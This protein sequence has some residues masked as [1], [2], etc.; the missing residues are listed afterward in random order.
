MFKGLGTALAVILVGVLLINC[1][2]YAEPESYRA[3]IFRPEVIENKGL[4]PFFYSSLSFGESSPNGTKDFDKNCQEWVQELGSGVKRKDVNFILYKIPLEFFFELYKED[5][6]EEVLEGNTF[7]AA[8]AKKPEMMAYLIYSKQCELVHYMSNAYHLTYWG[9]AM[10]VPDLKEMIAKAQEGIDNSKSKFLQKRYAFQL[11]KNTWLD[12]QNVVECAHLVDIHFTSPDKSGSIL[13]S[14]AYIFRAY[15]TSIKG[16][17]AEANY[18]LSKTFH[19]SDYRKIRALQ[20]F[21]NRDQHVEMATTFCKNDPERSVIYAMSAFS[22]PGKA[23]NEIKL[24]FSKDNGSEYLP[25]LI[26]REINKL[27]DWLYTPWLSGFDPAVFNYSTLDS[28]PQDNTHFVKKNY[29]K[30]ASYLGTFKTF[31]ESVAAKSSNKNFY[32][33][34]LAQL[35]ILSNNNAEA[36]KRLSNIASNAPE[37]I[38]LQKATAELLIKSKTE[39]IESPEI[40][41]EMGNSLA[42]LS[43]NLSSTESNKKVLNAV[44][45]F[46]SKQYQ[47]KGNIPM[48]ALFYHKSEMHKSEY[49]GWPASV[50]EG[51]FS[52]IDANSISFYWYLAYLNEHASPEQITS[53]I[54]L[55]ENPKQNELITYLC[56]QPL[57][58]KNAYLD[59]KATKL[60]NSD[61]LEEA[62]EAIKNVPDS[63][64]MK[65]YEFNHYLDE[66]PFIGVRDNGKVVRKTE[67]YLPSKKK[68]LKDLIAYKKAFEEAPEK[69]LEKGL[70][71]ANAYYNTTWFGNSWMYATYG[72]S[73]MDAPSGKNKTFEDNYFYC[74]KAAAYYKKV[75][76]S[77]KPD[78]DP[79]LASFIH[80]MAYLCDRN[81]TLF[82]PSSTASVDELLAK[83]IKKGHVS[84][85]AIHLKYKNTSTYGYLSTC[86]AFKDYVSSF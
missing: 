20:A 53:F 11:L 70:Y 27:E 50:D 64:W 9:E 85:E 46:L 62:Y 78:T 40:Q 30:D 79:E 42:F 32:N 17:T 67:P 25:T 21:S 36:Q 75:V 13:D 57:A 39:N 72:Q 82:L 34:A 76:S 24:V 8:L 26:A 2:Y 55:I 49:A 52:Y 59:L 45:M 54:S 66:S 69:N 28:E 83:F 47:T 15:E 12:S 71:V 22:Q 23:L 58:S 81:Q 31:V 80:F 33:L 68:F 51:D 7:I 1:G 38:L 19:A 84:L 3:V 6:L 4:Q 61:K 35:C 37:G 18:I 16:D 77:I 29:A 5:K 74:R 14:W 10:N 56:K 73:V 48:A 86:P 60:F 65:E 41:K 44:N 43:K 63:F